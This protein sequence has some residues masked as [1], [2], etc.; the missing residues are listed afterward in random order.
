M[1]NAAWK[2]NTWKYTSAISLFELRG[3]LDQAHVLWVLD[4]LI[5]VSPQR[6]RFLSFINSFNGNK[7]AR[8][9][10]RTIHS[11]LSSPTRLIRPL[12]F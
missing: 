7:E 5:N 3:V 12:F 2:E 9:S 8:S 10:V 1:V 6:L 4:K 11:D